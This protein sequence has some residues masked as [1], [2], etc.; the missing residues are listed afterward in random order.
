MKD[1]IKLFRILHGVDWVFVSET[2]ELFK[3]QP[4]NF[5]GKCYKWWTN[6]FIEY[7]ANFINDISTKIIYWNKEGLMLPWSKLWEPKSKW[8]QK[9]K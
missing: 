6:G 8:I 9:K 4:E 1:K 3:D 7:E 5:T 2:G